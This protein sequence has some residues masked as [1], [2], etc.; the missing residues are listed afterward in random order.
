MRRFS[1]SPVVPFALVLAVSAAACSKGTTVS[2]VAPS[3]PSAVSTAAPA[4]APAPVVGGA[5]ISGTVVTGS[6]PAL[7][8]S[9]S[10]ASLGSAGRVTVSVNGTSLSVISDDSGNFTLQN[11]PPGNLTLTITGAGFSAQVTLPP[12]S[13]NDQLRVTVRV[14][15]STATLDDEEI[16][17][18]DSKVEVEG[19]ISAVSGNTIT[20]GRLNTQVLV[21]GTASITKGGTTLTLTALVVGLRVHVRATKSGSALTATTVIVQTDNPGASSNGGGSNTGSSDDVRFSGTL[22]TA[23]TGA[24]PAITFIAGGKTV[25]TNAST[26]F[27]DG[28]C[29][30]LKAGSSIKGEGALQADGSILASE[31]QQ[32]GG[33]SDDDIES[34]DNDVSFSGTLASAPTG[35]C[36]AVTFTVGGTKVTTSASTKFD[37][38]TCAAL[39]AGDSV[40]G[41]GVKQADGSVL[42]SE[43]EKESGGGSGSNSGS[44]NSGGNGKG[45]GKGN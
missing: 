45:K 15:G 17:S 8:S 7:A 14:S 2:P 25:K 44:S 37:S 19:Q 42:A 10:V 26:R 20:V 4:P 31:V 33:T 23:P 21:P 36:P 18:P 41:E 3:T 13:D 43:V 9:F 32:I 24:C 38:V 6:A 22:A 5:R 39:A 12:V 40:K 28:S 27:D 1:I 30:A 29:S 34:D 11:V 16:E 35:T